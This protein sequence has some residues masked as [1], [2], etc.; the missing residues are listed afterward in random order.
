MNEKVKQEILRN[1]EQA[2]EE[3]KVKARQFS[4]VRDALLEGD[5]KMTE[6]IGKIGEKTLTVLHDV[7]KDYPSVDQYDAV[8][9]CINKDEH[10]EVYKSLLNNRNTAIN[11]WNR[12]GELV[13][14][15]TI[16]LGNVDPIKEFMPDEAYSLL[17]S[18]G[19]LP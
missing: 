8:I 11:F 19:A 17:C 18:E 13:D 14:D 12:V 16:A 10:P 15:F 4:E 3:R 9:R 2:R 5:K 7:M 6:A 1:I